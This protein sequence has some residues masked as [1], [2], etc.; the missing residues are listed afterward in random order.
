[1]ARGRRSGVS[2]TTNIMFAIPT[3][4]ANVWHL[5]KGSITFEDGFTA[6]IEVEGGYIPHVKETRGLTV[7]YCVI[8]TPVKGQGPQVTGDV[9]MM[10]C[11]NGR[12]ENSVD[13]ARGV[14]FILPPDTAEALSAAAAQKD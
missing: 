4:D 5:K 1:M 3:D 2:G 11:I 12:V 14:E 7:T 10:T 6:G 9:A 13:I 8:T